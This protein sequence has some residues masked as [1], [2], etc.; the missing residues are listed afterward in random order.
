M[1]DAGALVDGVL[2]ADRG[3]IARLLTLVEQGGPEAVAAVARLY[4]ESGKAHVVG[5][6][7]AP[8]AGKSTLTNRLIGRIRATGD[9]VGVLA[10]DPSSP[11][12]GGAILGDRVRMQDHAVDP[13]VFI[14]S[15]ATR[16][17]LGGLALAAPQALRVLD[18]AGIPWLI[19]ETVGVGQV[20]VEVAATADTVVVVL[21]PGWGDG[22]QAN[23]AGILEIAD[24]FVVNKADRDGLRQTVADLEGMLAL[25][26]AGRDGSWRPP[27]V[28]TV[29]S[30]GEG[31]D[32]LWSAILGHRDW[33]ATDDHAHDRRTARIAAELRAIVVARLVAG[34]GV[35]Y[36]G[37]EF[38]ALVDRIE[39]RT[40]D[41]YAAADE[42]LA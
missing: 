38:D 4:P 9:R 25:A 10:I 40:L 3:A 24:V 18:A 37:P 11:F 39:A 15:M 8:G 19:L 23:K 20:E 41:P 28:E 14:R 31:T 42:L 29:A 33:L 2:G 30:R 1:T 27:I 35:A 6:T 13:G 32:E 12:T 36:D 17:H 5:M 16:G 34:S 21:N 22:V 26:G 7:G